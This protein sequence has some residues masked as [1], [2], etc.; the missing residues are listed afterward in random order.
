MLREASQHVHEEAVEADD[1][2]SRFTKDVYLRLVSIFLIAC[3]ILAVII[4]RQ[5][6][7][8]TYE[9]S[10]YAST[11][12]P[13]L[14]L[15][16]LGFIGGIAIVVHEIFTSGHTQ[17]RSYLAGF[18][19]IILSATAF[20]C[21]PFF[22]GYV[23]ASSGDHLGH[24]GFVRDIITSGHLSERNP[25]PLANTLLAQ[26]SMVTGLTALEIVNLNT[27][28]IVPIFM[29]TA[30]LLATAV[31]PNEG[32]RL[33]AALIA[34]GTMAGISCFYLLPN[35][36][37]ALVLPLFFYCYFKRDRVPFSILTM[38]ILVVY[39]FFH[40]LSSIMIM[41]ILATM[42]L[43]RPVCA[44]L[45]R[46]QG[47]G[48]PAWM[49]SGPTVWPVLLE[50]AVFV[51]W[52]LT[53][54]VF[55]ANVRIFWESLSSFPG[56]HHYA[57]EAGNLAK[58]NVHGL[59]ILFLMFKLYGE[60]L[61][62][63]ALALIGAILLVRQLRRGVRDDGPYRLLLFGMWVP[64]ALVFFAADF[65]GVAALKVLA[66]D[67]MLIYI[68]VACVTFAAF[69]LWQIGTRLKSAGW[70]VAATCALL[71][72]A[73]LVNFFGHYYSPWVIRPSQHVT[74]NYAAGMT[75]YLATKD[76]AVPA[77]CVGTYPKWY[78]RATLGVMATYERADMPESPEVQTH[79][80][81]DNFTT[82]GEQYEGNIYVSI[83]RV[84]RI[85]YQT[86]WKHLGR[87]NDADF[88]RL[89]QDPTA[90]RIYSN[91]GLDIIFV[92][93]NPGAL[94]PGPAS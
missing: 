60:L 67:R 29:L 30:Y 86:V 63:A 45:L 38:A 25:Y 69:A 85:A 82:M 56:S 7:A 12:F 81:Y 79:F 42:E 53:R 44:R 80:G 18:V 26:I 91:G 87:W 24:V 64:I 76:P 50:A 93:D 10:I 55:R 23:A 71:I 16:L 3:V 59:G 15:L 40:P 49:I 17:S 61:V 14:A 4:A 1:P 28:L 39:P 72:P 33:L 31:L 19:V 41:L 20:L 13:V 74:H 94:A 37:S 5:S 22:R 88:Q 84:D 52:V 35:T 9:L 6:P 47:I 11:P 65:V 70:V 58:A 90:D 8:T 48:V 89:E 21:L 66:A 62:F 46:R 36:W 77:M 57:S 34:G 83:D 32:Q 73:L 68:E 2:G 75:W 51:P 92:S 43:T 54:K 78:S 27:A